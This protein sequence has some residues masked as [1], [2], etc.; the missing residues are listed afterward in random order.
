MAS[1][2]ERRKF[3]ATLGG[4]AVTWPR[5]RQPVMP[6]IGVLSGFQ[7]PV[8]LI[9]AFRQ[10]LGE[11][12]YVE[13]QNVTFDHRREAVTMTAFDALLM[14]GR[15]LCDWWHCGGAC[16]KSATSSTPIVLIVALAMVGRR[17]GEWWRT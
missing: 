10:V 4:A 6:E 5:A 8:H 12:G 15:N 14:S 17:R 1:H 7:V 2:I 11:V 13:R 3:L 16:S 9:A